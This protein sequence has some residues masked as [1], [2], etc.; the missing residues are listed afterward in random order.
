MEAIYLL[1]NGH[2][3]W[4]SE[5]EDIRNY[6]NERDDFFRIEASIEHN[7]DD[8]KIAVFHQNTSNQFSI[9]GKRT[10]RKRY[11]RL[12]CSNLFSPDQIE[13][14]MVSPSKRRE[15]MDHLISKVNLDYKDNLQRFERIH[16]QRNAYL[17][18]LSKRFYDTGEINIEDQQLNFW[19]K[20][21][22]S[23][24]A[25]IMAK[26]AEILE[27]LSNN[28]AGFRIHYN[29]SLKL[30]MFEDLAQ[31]EQ[32][33]QI[34]FKELAEY[35]K[36]DVALGYTK[37]GAH[38]DDWNITTDKDIKRFG[39]RGEKRMAISRLIFQ[40]QEIYNKYLGFYPILLLDDISSELDDNNV[41]LI[42]ENE[43]LRKQQVVVTTIRNL[44]INHNAKVNRIKL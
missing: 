38:R 22:A 6:L 32:L 27:E 41:K 33:S 23:A 30:N 5:L 15:F 35:F 3:P 34:H 19:T 2:S 4:T 28:D 40:T 18:K 21:F 37:T 16:R 39:S 25:K 1:T 36:R 31:I 26:R 9:D 13:L 8:F 7:M 14:L 17:K 20:E 42:L 11:S 12:T 29:P 10:I 24:S 44:K 43:T